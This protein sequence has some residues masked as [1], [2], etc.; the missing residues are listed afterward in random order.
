MK[1][2][3]NPIQQLNRRRSE[4]RSAQNSRGW[5]VATPLCAACQPPNAFSFGSG[6]PLTEQQTIPV[7]IYFSLTTLSTTGFGDADATT[8]DVSISMVACTL[9]NCGGAAPERMV[10]VPVYVSEAV[11]YSGLTL[12]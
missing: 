1:R 12:T 3:F 9:T 11:K 4:E 8:F 7:L 6:A 5:A 2:N 10:M